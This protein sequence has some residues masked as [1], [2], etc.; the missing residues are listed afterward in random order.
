MFVTENG[1]REIERAQGRVY[2]SEFNTGHCLSQTMCRTSTDTQDTIYHRRCV[3]HRRTHGTNRE[4]HRTAVWR[5][6]ATKKLPEE[7]HFKVASFL[8]LST[9]PLPS[10]LR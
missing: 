7:S 6:S 9:F 5:T 2:R 3:G 10:P 1:R 8:Y 4:E